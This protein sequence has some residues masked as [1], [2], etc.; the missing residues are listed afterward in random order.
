[1]L[2]WLKYTTAAGVDSGRRANLTVTQTDLP[3]LPAVKLTTTLR[4]G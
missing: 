4:K 3:I 1:M 2:A